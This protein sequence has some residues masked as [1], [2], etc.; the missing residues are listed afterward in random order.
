MRKIMLIAASL[1]MLSVAPAAAQNGNGN[2]KGN[3]NGNGKGNAG[4][5]AAIGKIDLS[6]GNSGKR[7]DEKGKNKAIEKAARQNAQQIERQI[8]R[9]RKDIRGNIDDARQV[10]QGNGNRDRF[11][12]NRDGNRVDVIDTARRFAAGDRTAE[13]RLFDLSQDGRLRYRPQRD[14]DYGLITG[15]PPGLAKKNNGCL[16]PGQAKKI[17]R[18]DRQLS[19]RRPYYDYLGWSPRYRNDDYAYSDGYAYRTGGSNNLITAF[20]PLVGGALF[21]GNSWPQQYAA[22]PVP[23]YYNSYYGGGADNYRYAD[24]TLFGVNPQSNTI[25]SIAGLLTGNDFTVGQR[26]PSGY[27]M[28]NVPYGYR[29]QYRDDAQSMY[30]YSDGY[31]YQVDPTTRLVQ[32]AIQLLT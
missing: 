7:G 4:G 1:A 16:P 24:N 26:I 19:Q 23:D 2:G 20:L 13:R 11:E 31:V 18:N 32:A 25:T 12:R 22:D 8:D 15:C 14:D 17:A 29:D 21:Q 6:P 27:D 5:N 3:G 10:V 28:Y 30:R 9:A